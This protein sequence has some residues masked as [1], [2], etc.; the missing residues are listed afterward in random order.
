[1]SKDELVKYLGTIA[2]SGSSKF[3]E[4]LKSTSSK[5]TMDSLIGQFGVGFYSTFIVSEYVEVISKTSKSNAT[6]WTSDGSVFLTK[7]K[8][9]IGN[10]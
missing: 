5:G 7:I 3:L 9:N 10:F 1:M 8:E 6:K 2:Y 4:E